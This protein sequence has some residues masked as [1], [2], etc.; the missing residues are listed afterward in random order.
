MKTFLTDKFNAVR[1]ILK[2]WKTVI[3][4]A[5]V[6]LPLALLEIAEQL[7]V[8]DPASILPEPWGQRVGL[9]LAVT[10]ILLRLVTTG[11]VGS[12]GDVEPTED[13][14]AGD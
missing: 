1:E 8:V 13:T 12:K 11:P 6:G 14:K 4:G 7:R 3:I 10:M 2:G 9:A 5:V